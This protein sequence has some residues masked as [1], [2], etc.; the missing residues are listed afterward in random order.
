PWDFHAERPAQAQ[1]LGELAQWLPVF[2]DGADPLPVAVIQMLFLALD[3]FLAERKFIRF[4][5]LD[6][7]GAAARGF[8]A[9]GDWINDGVP[10]AHK[11]A[12]ECAGSWYRDN[13]PVRGIW[14][15]ADEPVFHANLAPPAVVVLPAATESC[16]C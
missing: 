12:L 6:P 2:L 8:V 7:A 10:L 1:L 14:R 11:V 4:G 13:A 9:L 5:T 16:R 3:P 15:V